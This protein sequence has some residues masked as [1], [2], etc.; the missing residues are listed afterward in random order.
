MYHLAVGTTE[1]LSEIIIIKS[2]EISGY[3]NSLWY[4][5]ICIPGVRYR[6]IPYKEGYRKMVHDLFSV[7]SVPFFKQCKINMRNT[8]EAV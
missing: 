5:Y 2:F 3:P 1:R 4:M 7:C 8:E 6:F